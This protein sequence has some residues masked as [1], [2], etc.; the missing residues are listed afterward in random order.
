M[1]YAVLILVLCIVTIFPVS[2]EP[3][4]YEDFMKWYGP[5]VDTVNEQKLPPAKQF[6]I[7]ILMPSII[8]FDDKVRILKLSEANVVACVNPD[9]LQKLVQRGWGID[10]YDPDKVSNSHSV[11][12]GIIWK[13]VFD[14]EIPN[15]YSLIKSMKMMMLDYSELILWQP[16]T[17]TYHEN[18]MEILWTGNFRTAEISEIETYLKSSYGSLTYIETIPRG[19]I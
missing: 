2:A 7:G 17:I 19:C 3:V 11:E 18:V 16:M 15:E 9:T 8:C 13:L 12:C 14:S 5:L 1:K 10:Q 6:D 4:S